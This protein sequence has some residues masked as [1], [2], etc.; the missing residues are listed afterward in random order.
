MYKLTPTAVD[1]SS[2]QMV[3]VLIP[4]LNPDIPRTK[5]FQDSLTEALEK[6]LSILRHYF[7]LVVQGLQIINP[8]PKIARAVQDLFSLYSQPVRRV[9]DHACQLL[10]NS[11]TLRQQQ[12]TRCFLAHLS[13]SLSALGTDWKQV[14]GG[15]LSFYSRSD[16]SKEMAEKPMREASVDEGLFHDILCTLG[17]LVIY[18]SPFQI[19]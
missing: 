16:P 5:E 14:E 1:E 7:L 18:D 8:R 9:F 13:H 6:S 15:L 19:V 17:L 10:D 4:C 12:K 3:D 2:G 11:V